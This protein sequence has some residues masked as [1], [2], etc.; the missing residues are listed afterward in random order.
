MARVVIKQ[1]HDIR[2]A[3]VPRNEILPAPRPPEVAL[4]PVEFR[5]IKPKLLIKAGD[6]VQVGSPLF[7]DKARPDLRWP[8]PGG[9]VVSQIKFGERRTIV[10]IVIRLD[11][12]EGTLQ[13]G[14]YRDHEIAALG[15]ERIVA[16]LTEG[17]LWPLFRQ[18][19]FN[20][21]V[22]PHQTPR[23]IFISAWNTAPLTVNL[24]LA[25]QGERVAFQAGLDVLTQLSGGAVHL[26]TSANS[27]SETFTAARGVATHTF[28]GPHPAGN[29]GIQ[30]HHLAPLKPGEVVWIL[31]AQQVV[32]LGKFFLTGKYDPALVVS[33]GG[34]GVTDP[35]HLHSRTGARIPDLLEGR[36]APGRKRIIS[37]DVLT[38]RNTA[39]EDYLGF[40]DA[41]VSVLLEEERR[42]FLGMLRAGTTHTRYS[43]TR[44]FGGLK[45]IPFP[46]T[47][48]QNG[49]QR[50]LVP[51]NAWERVLP[52]DILPNALYRSILAQDIEEMEKLGLYECDEEDFAL[53]SF[54]CP[55]KI[56]LGGVIRQGLELLQKEG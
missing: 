43:L 11:E 39:R 53:C 21:A 12:E 18:R 37:G 40:Y 1:G 31:G 17:H 28:S 20:V 9:G 48:L 33:L 15:R 26:S 41:A 35:V 23:D 27:V 54:A 55:S 25:L 8:S 29:V 32:T 7:F 5:G 46:F 24:D 36:L 49:S 3:G 45:K 16:I 56:D 52:M 30:I 42:E 50:A 22:D 47:T 13:Y 51:I 44:A 10:Q 34:P 2:I 14:A 4:R 6:P 19:P 38:G